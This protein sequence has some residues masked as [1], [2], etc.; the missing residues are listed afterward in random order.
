MSDKERRI[1]AYHESGHAIVATRAARA[2]S[3]AQDLDRAARLRRAR[4]HDAAAARGSLPDDARRICSASSSVLLGGRSAE[5]IAFG[6]IS[7][8]AQN[9]LQRATDIARAMVTEFGMSDALGA[10]NYDGHQ[11]GGVPR[12]R[13][14]RSER[15]NYAEETALQDRRRGEADPRP[16]RTT[17]RAQILRDHRETLDALSERLLEKEVIEADELKAIL[18][19]VPPKDENA[20]CRPRSR[21]SDSDGELPLRPV[22]ARSRHAP[23]AAGRRRSAPVSQG[24]RSAAPADRRPRARARRAASSTSSSG[25]ET[26]VEDTNLAGLVAEIRRALGDSPEAPRYVRTMHRFGYWFIADISEA[27]PAMLTSTAG[28]GTPAIRYWLIWDQRQ[29]PLFDGENIIGRAPDA[30]VWLEA[31][32]VSRHHASIRLEGEQAT[33]E[34]LGSKNGTYVGGERL[35]TPAR[36]GRRRSDPSSARSS[37]PSGFPRR[38]RRRIPSEIFDPLGR[39]DPRRSHD[40]RQDGLGT[41][42]SA[43]T[44]FWRRSAS[45]GGGEVF[46]AW[47]PR[48]D[49]EVALKIL[50]DHVRPQIPERLPR[51]VSRGAGRAAP[52]ITPT[53]SPC[54]TP[55]STARRRT[56]C[57]SHR[58]ADAARGDPDGP[59]AA[60][61]AARSVAQIA[62]GLA[63]AHDAGIVHRDL[64][65][66]NIMVTRRR[67]RQ[68]SGLRPH[69][70]GSG[71]AATGA[72]DPTGRLTSQTQTDIGPPRRDVPYMS[73]EQARGVAQRLPLG[74]VFVRPDSLRAGDRPSAVQARH[75]RRDAPR[76]HQRRF[77]PPARF[78][79]AFRCSCS[80]SSSAVSRRTRGSATARPRICIAICARFAI[81]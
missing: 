79:A 48:L 26:H 54:S 68:D 78:R 28:A 63:A 37:C 19:P 14:S 58:R 42:R 21:R 17:R 59:G 32:G 72:L 76:D 60:E 62:D 75:A 38:R 50:R 74:S 81:A 1:V 34:D 71:H 46:R 64:K 22:R 56:S 7:T 41:A 44:R 18:G 23:P 45:G 65:P 2:R 16:R 10:V 57:R 67:R 33:I 77:R 53:S 66:E 20:Y 61:A 8:G 36:A 3:G 43:P 69:L 5:E 9:D 6:E 52:S 27:A 35:T 13:R 11:R 15:G 12:Q 25:R 39:I 4:L 29:I 30:A 70:A 55:R 24:L 47:D 80:G 51:F 31:P 40:D 73:P 49:R